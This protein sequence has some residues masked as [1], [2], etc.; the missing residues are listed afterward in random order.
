MFTR[1]AS[2]IF[3]LHDAFFTQ[4]FRAPLPFSAVQF[5]SLKNL[6]TLWLDDN[7]LSELPICL[8]QLSGLTTLRLSGNDLSY[9]PP[10]ISSLSLLEVLVSFP[11][12]SHTR[13]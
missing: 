12:F 2:N 4:T 6:K 3:I 13:N 8:C 1:H 7:Q 9:I 10:S 5:G 11:V